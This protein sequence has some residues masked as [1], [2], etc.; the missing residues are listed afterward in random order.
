MN[1]MKAIGKCIAALDS[2]TQGAE[3]QIVS[4]SWS[5]ITSACHTQM[6]SYAQDRASGIQSLDLTFDDAWIHNEL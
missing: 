4:W 6:A 5:A 2:A 1:V 3:L